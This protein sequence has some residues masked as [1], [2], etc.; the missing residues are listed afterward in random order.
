MQG[1]AT[2]ARTDGRVGRI[3][4]LLGDHATVVLSGT[5]LAQELE[6]SRSAVW[7]FVQELRRLGVEI[8]GH[9]ATGYR[10]E[11]VP[12]LVLPEV[13]A[14]LLKGTLFARHIH[15][16]FRTAS[17]NSLAMDAGAAGEPEGSVFLAEEQTAGRGR[18]G[19]AWHSEAS[20]GIYC[21]VLLR[22]PLAPADALALSLAAGL[23][24]ADAIQ[25]VTRLRPDLRWPNDILV[26]GKK[27]AG[28]LTELNAEATRVRY[29]VVGIGVNVNHAAFPAALAAEATS[30]RLAGGQPWSRVE[31][32]AALL[33]S[34]DREYRAL[35]RDAAAGRAE[36]I[37]RFEQLSSYAR[38]RRV[39]V[40]EQGGYEGITDGL[41]ALG[42][43]RV[44]T[45]EGV[46]TV[47][48][49]GV[50]EIE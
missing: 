3:V 24:T 12:D 10:L 44:K 16:Y 9:P 50:R 48:S 28:I 7:R 4:R 45:P 14:P 30:L 11:K 27:V 40:D 26:G 22:P 13:L 39:R 37:R 1:S 17:T 2:G 25:Q 5:K 33:K 20:A 19:H 36:L 49:G 43:L 31:L 42:F 46:R 8:A 29:A 38:G 18:G 35:T 21:S 41:D 23:A 47:L 34:L 6:T 32:A 15:H